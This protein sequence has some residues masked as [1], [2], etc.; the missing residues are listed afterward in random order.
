[1]PLR[2][3]VERF[4]GSIMQAVVIATAC[5][6]ANFMVVFAVN[7]L[8]DKVIP[9]LS[10]YLS[11]VFLPHGV[12]VLATAVAGGRAIPGLAIGSGISAYFLWGI[13]DF[14]I[15]ISSTLVAATT[16]WIVFEMLHKVGFDAYFLSLT[17]WQPPVRNLVAAGVLC[18]VLNGV[19]MSVVLVSM[20]QPPPFSWII[21]TIAVGD[22]LGLLSS[23]AI[24]RFSLRFLLP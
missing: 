21:L 2:V 22:M 9:G 6:L 10:P 19:L 17:A 4:S 11:L 8:Q 15:L 7:P 12:K 5:C 23:W 13:T 14:S 16:A 3:H 24:I 18:S 1:L 20:D